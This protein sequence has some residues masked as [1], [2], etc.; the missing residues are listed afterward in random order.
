MS[1]DNDDDEE[2]DRD[3]NCCCSKRASERA[4]VD[5]TQSNHCLHLDG[6]RYVPQRGCD[7][8]TFNLI[9]FTNRATQIKHIRHILIANIPLA[10]CI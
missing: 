1:D 6:Y 2:N 9:V 10:G 3:Y 8:A 4:V 7:C 5:A